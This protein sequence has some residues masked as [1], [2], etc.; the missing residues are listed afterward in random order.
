MFLPKTKYK[1]KYSYGE[2]S[3]PDGTSYTGPYIQTYDGRYFLGDNISEATTQLIPPSEQGP[4]YSPSEPLSPAITKLLNPTFPK[5]TEQDY[6]NG[7]YIRYFLKLGKF[8]KVVEVG[9][10]EFDQAGRF[11]EIE[12]TQVEWKL[13]GYRNET[14]KNGNLLKAVGDINQQSL[15]KLLP[16]L[17]EVKYLIT[18]NTQYCRF[19]EDTP[20][21]TSTLIKYFKDFILPET[22][23]G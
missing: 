20:A 13:V 15:D 11:E 1:I 21:Q 10:K 9:K 8:K 2:F 18:D 16:V 22:S 14:R 5:P 4:E 3:N 23:T 17:P 6:L 7:S 12:S 19:I